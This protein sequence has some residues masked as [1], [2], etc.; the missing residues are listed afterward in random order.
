MKMIK[1]VIIA[2]M[3][4]AGVAA[5]QESPCKGMEQPGKP[6]VHKFAHKGHGKHLKHT[7]KGV[8]MK[9][10]F[11][12]R[13]DAVKCGKE[14]APKRPQMKVKP[15][16]G[17]QKFSGKKPGMKFVFGA[18][19]PGMKRGISHRPVKAICKRPAMG[20]EQKPLFAKRPAMKPLTMGGKIDISSKMLSKRPQM[21]HVFG[22]RPVKRGMKH[23]FGKRPQKQAKPFGKRG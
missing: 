1:N 20:C 2:A 19:K 10:E 12:L 18:K 8:E 16:F 23:Y 15:V 7:N 11:A 5:A 21:K 6:F 17:G 4:V 9:R 22:K 3:M 14:F 13:K